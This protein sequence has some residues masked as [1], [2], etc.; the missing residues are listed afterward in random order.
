MDVLTMAILTIAILTMARTGPSYYCD[1]YSG[2]YRPV[3]LTALWPHLLR[4]VQADARR[5][6][7]T[8]RAAQAAHQAGDTE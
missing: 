4:R 2:S 6:H 8:A 1:T 7:C 3:I 5:G